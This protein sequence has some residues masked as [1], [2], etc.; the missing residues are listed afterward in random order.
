MKDLNEL[1]KQ[2]HANSVE[3]GYHDKEEWR[4]VIGFEGI[5]KVS[6]IGR[7]MSLDRTIISN[8]GKLMPF[9]GRVLKYR[10]GSRGYPYL[11][12]SSTN[13]RKTV[14]VHRL[15]AE[16]FIP[17]PHSKPQVNHIDENKLNNKVSNLEWC[18][19]KENCNHGTHNFRV[20]LNGRNSPTKSLSVFQFSLNGKFIKRWDSLCEIERQ[21]GF[22]HSNISTCCYGVKK[23]MNGFIWCFEKEY[24]KELIESKVDAYNKSKTPKKVMQLSLDGDLIKIWSSSKQIFKELGIDCGS[25]SS[26]CNG[27]RSSSNGYIWRYI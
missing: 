23:S 13:I 21:L 7:V 4:D 26:V 15:V 11:T 16:S 12:L 17:N 3:K 10:T 9:V 22:L 18:S 5:Y 27:R 2:V 1:A 6:N 14:K 8:N 19:A 24:S 25:I 20:S